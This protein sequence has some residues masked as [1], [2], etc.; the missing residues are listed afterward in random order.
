[1]NIDMNVLEQL[2]KL[3][4][5]TIEKAVAAA[6]KIT[7]GNKGINTDEVNKVLGEISQ[8]DSETLKNLLNNQSVQKLLNDKDTVAKIKKALGK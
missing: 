8:K 2:K 3:D 7:G 6:D 5:N 4:K 1:M